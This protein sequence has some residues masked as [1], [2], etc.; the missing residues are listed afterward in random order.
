MSMLSEVHYTLLNIPHLPVSIVLRFL[1]H[2]TYRQVKLPQEFQTSHLIDKFN[3]MFAFT[4]IYSYIVH[5]T[6][7]I[8][9]MYS[10]VYALFHLHCQAL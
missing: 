6:I 8:Y 3:K 5:E 9:C 2:C 10:C 1:Q 7:L 4:C